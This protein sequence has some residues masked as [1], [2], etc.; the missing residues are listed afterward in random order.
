M[1]DRLKGKVALVL[2]AGVAGEGWSNGNAAAVTFAREGAKVVC[3]DMDEEAAAATAK[4]IRDEGFEAAFVRCDVASFED[5]RAAVD[6]AIAS[7]GRIDVLHYNAGMSGRGGP[8]ETSEE[9]WDRVYDVN[10]KGAFLACK[11]VIPHMQKQGGGSIVHISSIASVGWTGHALL[12]YQSSK[13][14]LNQ[15]TR[16]VAVQHGAEGIRCNCI[17]PGLIDSP[18]IM[19]AVLPVFGG[20]VEK[21][22]AARGQAVPMKRMGDVWDVANA[23]LFLASDEAKYVTGVLLP[24]DGGIT[25]SLPH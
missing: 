18:R 23:A 12:S 22:R 2:G 17:L 5:L 6:K 20:D 11:L 15:L 7:Y 13:A 21:M 4:L 25:C 10:V 3:A 1:A 16:M 8:L 9:L 24:V 19:N 14:A